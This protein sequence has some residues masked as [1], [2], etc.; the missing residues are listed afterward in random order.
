MQHPPK[1]PRRSLEK[2]AHS[3]GEPVDEEQHG[4][5]HG[6]PGYLSKP[7]FEETA[8]RRLG[9]NQ[10][11]IRM[12]I[13]H[14]VPAISCGPDYSDAS[15]IPAFVEVVT[16]IDGECELEV[17][18]GHEGNQQEDNK[19]RHEHQAPN[20]CGQGIV[21]SCTKERQGRKM[22]QTREPGQVRDDLPMIR[23]KADCQSVP[24]ADQNRQTSQEL[25]VC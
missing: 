19:Y 18:G 5:D 25:G 1:L 7:G 21:Y 8:R 9:E 23:L 22:G 6:W 13:H 24:A 17:S 14:G 10:D 16:V 20:P 15:I 11:P 4:E 3:H 12:L 2:L